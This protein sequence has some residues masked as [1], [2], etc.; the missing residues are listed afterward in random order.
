MGILVRGKDCS[1]LCT[2]IFQIRFSMY[3]YSGV[4]GL[5]KINISWLGFHNNIQ[6]KN[7]EHRAPSKGPEPFDC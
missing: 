4:Q 5:I 3:M 2:G 7:N 6:K 1:Q